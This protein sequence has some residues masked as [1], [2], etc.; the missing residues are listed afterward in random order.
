MPSNIIKKLNDICNPTTFHGT[1]S[2]NNSI[3]LECLENDTSAVLKKV[4]ISGFDELSS[5]K[6]DKVKFLDS[7]LKKGHKARKACDAIIFCTI[8][9]DP[10]IL[11]FDMKSSTPSDEEHIYQLKSG[12]LG[13]KYIL[14]LLKEFEGIS[15]STNWSYR[16]FIF[17]C[18]NNKRETLP[19]FQVEITKNIEPNKPHICET[20]N[21][22]CI[23]VR[24]LLGKPLIKKLS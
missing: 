5:F 9:H 20:N 4:E 21:E 10:F 8:D 11:I 13:S 18:K 17:H 3:T 6:L 1:K 12:L 24:K 14:D 15:S 19:E 7:L 16:Y 2:K 23:P 22:E